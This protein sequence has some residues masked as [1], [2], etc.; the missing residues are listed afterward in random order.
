MKELYKKSKDF[1]VTSP[2]VCGSIDHSAIT[3][4]LLGPAQI[5][6]LYTAF[7][8]AKKNRSSGRIA[9][10]CLSLLLSDLFDSQEK[11]GGRELSLQ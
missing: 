2:A 5:L 9:T 8:R 10:L 6:S 4:T 3:T 11:T 7:D 1:T